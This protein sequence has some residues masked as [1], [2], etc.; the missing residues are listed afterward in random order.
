MLE[1]LDS[2]NTLLRLQE[3]NKALESGL[4]A[5]ARSMIEKMPA[6]DVALILESS[7]PAN[8]KVL[9]DLTD[10]D[11]QGEILEELNEDAKDSIIDLMTPSHLVAATEGMDTDDIA[12][13][14]RGIPTSLY[15][16]VLEKMDAQDRHRVEQ[17]FAYPEDTAGSIMN[18]DTITLRPDVSVDVVLRYLRI[19]G[20]LPEGTD[21]LYVVDDDDQLIGDVPLSTLLTVDPA[22]SIADVMDDKTETLSVELNENEIAQLFER[23][24]WISAPVVDKNNHLLG[25]ITIDDVVDIIRENAD[26]TMMGMAGMD[27][28]EDTFA[29]I[30]PSAK[31]R[32]VWLAVNLIAAFIAASVSNMFEATL[33]QMATLAV[34]MTIVPSMGGI[35]GNQT[36]ALVI[37]GIAV[38]HI[39]DTNTRWLIGKEAAIG[40]LNGMVW[41]LIVAT[42]ITLW[43]GDI[44]IGFIIAGAMFINLSAAGIA[45]VTIPLVMHKYKIDPAL[46]GGMALTTVTDVIGLFSFLGMA[47]LVLGH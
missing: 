39:N 33:E 43:K 32:T 29:P 47:T 28:D 9:W 40:I 14:L 36:L 22:Q 25:R 42:A 44:M 46:A 34:L 19:K 18:T 30:L 38:G 41:A 37:R 1:N 2:Q 12:Y 21:T 27:D 23:H 31:R 20:E 26:H 6:C 5:S 35:A 3:V 10:Y 17:A 24:D 8:R 45:G 7:P 4:F 13:I 16:A 11:Q 15:K